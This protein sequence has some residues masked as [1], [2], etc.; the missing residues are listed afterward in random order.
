VAGDGATREN[1]E[2]R[3][4]IPD[5]GSYP[6]E[7]ERWWMVGADERTALQALSKLAFNKDH[8][9][10]IA[11][12]LLGRSDDLTDKQ[13]VSHATGVPETTVYNELRALGRLGVLSRTRDGSRV[14]FAVVDGPFWRWCEEL[15]SH[16]HPSIATEDFDTPSGSSMS[17][18]IPEP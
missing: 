8:R 6:G 10:T 14:L 12:H 9:L 11:Q 17:L 1:P 18:Q 3:F 2:S 16:T 7:Q 4:W 5:S 15:L 13:A